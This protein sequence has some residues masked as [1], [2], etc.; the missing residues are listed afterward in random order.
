MMNINGHER[1][2][3]NIVWQRFLHAVRKS[4]TKIV[5]GFIFSAKKY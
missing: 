4:T 2:N 3:V 5:S 1:V